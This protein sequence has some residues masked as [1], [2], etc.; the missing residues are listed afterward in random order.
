[1]IATIFTRHA[2]SD[3]LISIFQLGFSRLHSLSNLVSTER[4]SSSYDAQHVPLRTNGAL[5]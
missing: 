5:L 4:P 2:C 3:Q 1:M